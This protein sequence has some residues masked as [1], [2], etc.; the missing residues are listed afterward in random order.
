MALRLNVTLTDAQK[1]E[2]ARIPREAWFT[3][4]IF[5]NAESPVHPGVDLLANNDMKMQ[6]TAGFGKR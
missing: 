6:L 1:Q 5:N 3:H 4:I 2:M